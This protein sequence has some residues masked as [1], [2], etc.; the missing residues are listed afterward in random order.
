[1]GKYDQTYDLGEND[2]N[3]I[4]ICQSLDYIA[5]ELAELNRLKRIE[6][7]EKSIHWS[8]DKKE[9]ICELIDDDVLDLSDEV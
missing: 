6:L 2:N 1:M 7:A 9:S 5:N 4:S 3:T 8:N